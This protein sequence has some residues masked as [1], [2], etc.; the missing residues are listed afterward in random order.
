MITDLIELEGGYEGTPHPFLFHG[1]SGPSRPYSPAGWCR[2]I[3]SVFKRHSGVALS[4]KDLR[5][6]FI[7]FLRSSHN[8]EA[9]L[10]SC[11]VAMRHSNS[12][13][14]LHCLSPHPHVCCATATLRPPSCT[15]DE[16]VSSQASAHYDKSKNDKLVAAAKRL[17]LSYAAQF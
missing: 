4:P 9:L 14:E 11:A 1:N 17:C 7:T 3:K 5:S 16:S 2:L 12:M 6:S 8:N 15:V 13:Q 10:K